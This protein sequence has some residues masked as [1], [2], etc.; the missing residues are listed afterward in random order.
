MLRVLRFP[1]GECKRILSV[2]GEHA[3]VGPG[4]FQQRLNS[5]VMLFVGL[6]ST[7]VWRQSASVCSCLIVH[8]R[9]RDV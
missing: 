4:M 2:V 1:S 7:K 6:D 3:T 9:S 5:G 8:E